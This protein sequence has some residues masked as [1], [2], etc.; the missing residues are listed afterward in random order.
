MRKAVIRSHDGVKN[1]IEQLF[2][3][4]EEGW[5]LILLLL[6][7]VLV[8]ISNISVGANGIVIVF[9]EVSVEETVDIDAKLLSDSEWFSDRFS[10]VTH[11]CWD[12]EDSIMTVAKVTCSFHQKLLYHCSFLFV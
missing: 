11:T 7:A 12:S 2:W 4:K 9:W 6:L 3:H 10:S 5:I 1:Q 8:G